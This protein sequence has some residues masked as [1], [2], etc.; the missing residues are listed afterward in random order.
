MIYRLDDPSSG[1]VLTG[2]ITPTPVPSNGTA[3]VSVTLP[4]GTSNGSHTIYAV[5]NLGDQPG[6]SITV[7]RPQ[8]GTSVIAKSAGGVA[9]YIKQGGTYFV[10]A[11]ATGSGNPPAGLS[12]LKADVSSVT[13]GATAVTLSNGS[14]TVDGQSY[15]YR[16]AQQTANAVLGAGSKSYALTLPTRRPPPRRRE[17]R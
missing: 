9:G 14:F 1:T 4:A 17:S 8:I 2:S 5:G 15:N 12:T 13:T 10:Y 3:T 16:S 6:A 7:N 11:N